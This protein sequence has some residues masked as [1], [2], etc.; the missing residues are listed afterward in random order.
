MDDASPNATFFHFLIHLQNC[1]A[2]ISVRQQSVNNH[3]KS[4]SS[5]L[6]NRIVL[7]S[8]KEVTQAQ[9]SQA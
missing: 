9:V 8:Q 7:S 3:G 4:C 1:M 2:N 5:Q 6:L